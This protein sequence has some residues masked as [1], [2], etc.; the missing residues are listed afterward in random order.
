MNVEALYLP[1]AADLNAADVRPTRELEALNHL[2]DDRDALMK[3]YDEN[4]YMF[5]R[6][7]LNEQSV[8]SAR[9]EMFAVMA[10]HELIESDA[11]EPIWTG[12]PFAG[13][14][15]ESPEFSGI[16]KRLLEHPDNLEIMAKILGEPACMVPIVKYRTY[17]P[18][19]PITIP[20][21]DGFYSPGIVD[22]KPVWIPLTDCP[23]EVGGLTIAIAQNTR[24][25][26]HNIA[27]PTPFPIP[28]GVIPE[29]SWGTAHYHPGDVL[30]V[31][32]GTPHCSMAN[33]SD[34]CRVTLD[35]RVQSAVHPGAVAAT[36]VSVTPA[37]ITADCDGLGRRTFRV[38]KETFIRVLDP[39][40]REPFE[41][42]V[43]VTKPGMRLVLVRNGDYVV[44]LRRAAEG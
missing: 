1:D 14:L 5:L 38:D 30:I 17:P 31:H 13:G 42:F 40:V 25:Y 21:Q 20:H 16:S 39:G 11:V 41:R 29:D 43:E 9:K 18:G 6:K 35:T 19:G 10:R 22:Y 36:V 4:G 44:M 34:R 23:R 24:G 8:E 32:P 28:V 12:K 2:L 37:S 7:V 26:L 3:F 15:E 33:T 27:K